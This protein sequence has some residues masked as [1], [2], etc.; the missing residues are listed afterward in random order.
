MNSKEVEHLRQRMSKAIDNLSKE[1][2][3]VRT[4]RAS[5]ALLDH[6]KVDYY[7]T[8]V[9]IKQLAN[10]SQQDAR[11]LL[12]NV[13]DKN[14]L[15][16][17]DKAIRLS[18]LGLTPQVDGM[19]LRIVIPTLTQERRK[20]LVKVVKK[21]AEEARVA[22]RNIRRDELEILEKKVKNKEISEDDLKRFKNEFQKITDSF[23][24]EIDKL[25][26]NKERE[27]LND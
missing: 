13:Y 27:I 8:T 18:D 10:V 7:G 19:V 23:I 9:P 11:T 16:A 14:A 1:F 15:Q 4:G 3:S 6:V 21:M 2:A 17:V 24:Q 26:S 22:V 5:P 25:L 12:I 20:E